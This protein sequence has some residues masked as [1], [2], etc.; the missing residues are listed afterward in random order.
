MRTF[1]TLV[2]ADFKSFVRDRAALFW[3]L[4]FPLVFVV[5]FGAIFSG[6]GG[7]KSPVGIVDLDRTAASQALA[8]DPAPSTATGGAAAGAGFALS[9]AFDLLRYATE[10]D[11]V[12]AMKS[13]KVRAVIVIPQGFGAAVAAAQS[14]GAPGAPLPVRLMVDPSSPQQAATIQG[15]VGSLVGTYNI[16]ASGRPPILSLVPETVQSQDITAVAYLVPSI[17]GMA[18]MQLGLFSAIP[19]VEQREKL[20][21]KRISATPIRRRTFIGAAVVTRL[22][23]GIVQAAVIL[24]VAGLLFHITLL[25]NPFLFLG[26]VVLGALTFIAVGYVVA[27]FAPTEDSANQLT[28]IIQFPMMFLS[29]IFF[30]MDSLP[31]V[32]K[33]VAAFIPL[34][35]L[36]DALRQVMVNGTPFVPLAVGLAVLAGWLVVCFGIS[37]RFFR[38]Q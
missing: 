8:P 29:G 7:G 27:S 30:P 28:S 6:T 13:G 18:L 35:Y 38:W 26:I 17:L 21:L 5:L 12:S 2:V 3:T 20:I 16:V 19:I 22:G 34:T 15:V 23:V 24:A 1:T 14:G 9:D 4:L 36:G 37:A 11:A 25:G 31:D 33:G 10:A 32:L